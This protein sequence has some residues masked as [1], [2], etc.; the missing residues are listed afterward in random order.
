[1]ILDL[2]AVLKFDA[3]VEAEIFPTHAPSARAL[4]LD[5]APDLTVLSPSCDNL[6]YWLEAKKTRFY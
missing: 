2:L 3:F 4:G 1:M 5:T 6:S